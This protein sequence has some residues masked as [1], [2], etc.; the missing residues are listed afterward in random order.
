M[1]SCTCSTARMMAS[2]SMSMA[3]MT[4]CSASSEYG[5]RRSLYASRA[6]GA[7]EYST[8]E[9]DIF[10]GRPF[11]RRVPK[12]RRG[13][14]GDD[15]RNAVIP[16]HGPAELADRELG[17]EER[18][19]GECSERDDDLGTNQLELAYQIRAARGDLA[20]CR[21]AI[22]RRSVLEHV[23]DEHVF[24]AQVNRRQNL[25]QEL[26]RLADERSPGLV[27]GRAGR[28]ADTD[29]VGVGISLAGNRVL[30]RREQRAARALRNRRR[31]L[32]DRRELSGGSGEQLAAG[33]ADDDAG[34]SSRRRR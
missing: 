2:P 17:V 21:V 19:R 6:G 27:L 16:V 24:P 7:I 18:L 5:G 28:F 20:G 1:V 9:L 4:A 13:V 10:P 23:A 22:A 31:D 12:K 30:R 32:L 26:T 11:P 33:G 3:A 15:E 14:V 8:G 29:E 25:R 34:G